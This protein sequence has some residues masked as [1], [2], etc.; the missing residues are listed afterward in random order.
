MLLDHI[1]CD[2]QHLWFAQLVDV[3]R[4]RR[5]FV[6]IAIGGGGDDSTSFYLW[7]VCV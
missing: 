5:P 6:T 7:A 1:F 4:L 3:G 2:L